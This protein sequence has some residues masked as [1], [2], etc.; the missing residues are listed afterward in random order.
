MF[1]SATG[2][3]NQLTGFYIIAKLTGN[4]LSEHSRI[5]FRGEP[6]TCQ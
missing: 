2:M 1:Q 5:R 6:F 4:E 3:A